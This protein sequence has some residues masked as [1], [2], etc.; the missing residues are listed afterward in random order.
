MTGSLANR[1]RA[2][3]GN[4]PETS[5]SHTLVD[6]RACERLSKQPRALARN[7]FQDFQRF[8]SVAT[9]NLACYFAHLF[10]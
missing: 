4:G 8:R 5:E 9:L 7:E 1:M 3:S 10:V 2:A 6:Y